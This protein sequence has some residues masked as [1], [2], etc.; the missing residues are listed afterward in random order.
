MT[1]DDPF[2]YISA[3]HGVTPRARPVRLVHH[4]PSSA[5]ADQWTPPTAPRPAQETHRMTQPA[6]TATPEPTT[7]RI[8]HYVLADGQH[9]A[10]T[11]TNAFG[12]RRANLTVH[13]DQ[14]N[15]VDL[16]C[17]VQ[18]ERGTVWKPFDSC[19][20]KTA[21]IPRS[22]RCMHNGTLAV[23]SAEQ[24]EQDYRPG[25]WHYPERA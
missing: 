20:A 12:G 16:G 18:T 2:D 14:M 19:R 15:D 24:D 13:L 21:L 7:G 23:G 9:R 8:V 6:P 22:A 1:H 11:I 3:L 25:T 17:D 5:P 4:A 10:A